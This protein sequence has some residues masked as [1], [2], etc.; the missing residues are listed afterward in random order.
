MA[1][2]KNFYENLREA[3]MRLLN[4]VVLYDEDPY[5]II[6]LTNHK[7]DGIYRAYMVPLE[8]SLSELMVKDAYPQFGH[9]QLD[10]TQ[11]NVLGAFLDEWL[12]AHPNS[13]IVRKQANSPMFNRFRPFPLGMMNTPGSGVYYLARSPQRHREQGLT[14]Q[15][16]RSTFI[17]V[18][19]EDPNRPQ[20]R[21]WGELSGTE[22]RDCIKGLYPT[23][24]E[25]VEN[26]KNP[27]ITNTGAGFHR[28]FAVVRGPLDML[29]LA[30]RTDIVGILPE[31]REKEEVL[32][33]SKFKHLREVVEQTNCFETVKV[34]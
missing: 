5:K 19:S 17:S 4:T 3:Q 9:I 10:Q 11:E 29:F 26:L 21:L 23:F 16:I 34:K 27:E 12:E 14:A 22:L 30:Y 25:C 1:N 15:S 31:G 7:K 8:F 6:A 28:E 33:G 20:P 13:P 24:R 18:N 2:H 32:L